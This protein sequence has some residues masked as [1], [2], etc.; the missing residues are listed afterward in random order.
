MDIPAFGSIGLDFATTVAPVVTEEITTEDLVGVT[1][2]TGV[3]LV[4]E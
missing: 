4:T 2:E 1:T 3:E